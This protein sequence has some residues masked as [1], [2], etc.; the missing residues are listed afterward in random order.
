MR[1]EYFRAVYERK[2]NFRDANFSY[3]NA[4]NKPNVRDRPVFFSEECNFSLATFRKYRHENL[5]IQVADYEYD[6]TKLRI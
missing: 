1:A 2:D 5:N 3:K 4:E 6:V